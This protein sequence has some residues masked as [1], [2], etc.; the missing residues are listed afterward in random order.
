MKS[1]KKLLNKNFFVNYVI[2]I[3][4]AC[5]SREYFLKILPKRVPTN[6]ADGKTT[7]LI[8]VSFGDIKNKDIQHPI[9][10]VIDFNPNIY[11]FIFQFNKIRKIL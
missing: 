1:E 5:A 2:I 11:L 7:E 9:I 4:C 8:N 3:T 6:T 10:C